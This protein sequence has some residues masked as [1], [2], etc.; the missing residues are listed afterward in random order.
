MYYTNRPILISILGLLLI[1]IGLLE[2]LSGLALVVWGDGAWVKLAGMFP[3]IF[4]LVTMY[5]GY[6]AFKGYGWVWTLIM[7]FMILHI[8][9]SVAGL[10][11]FSLGFIGI[12]SSG[13]VLVLAVLVML[14]MN[15]SKVRA[16]FGKPRGFI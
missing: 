13:L 10:I 9:V 12:P 4:G 3:L 1:V 14:Y 5:L 15:T 8:V 2:L 7:I 11:G 6:A 16:W